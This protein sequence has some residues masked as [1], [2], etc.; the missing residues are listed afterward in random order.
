MDLVPLDRELVVEVQGD[1]I[2]VRIPDKLWEI[3][4]RCWTAPE[5]RP[6]LDWIED[7]LKAAMQ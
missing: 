5:E 2:P 6:T 1:H 7:K 4:E 3:I